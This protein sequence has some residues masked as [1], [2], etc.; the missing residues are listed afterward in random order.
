[1]TK[2]DIGKYFQS[3]TTFESENNIFLKGTDYQ[4]LDVIE[5]EIFTL[6]IFKGSMMF[7]DYD[8]EFKDKFIKV[9]DQRTQMLN[10]IL[11]ED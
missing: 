11:Y 9:E 6:Y 2:D 7:G 5:E 3:K 1:M 8:M 10:K 4:L